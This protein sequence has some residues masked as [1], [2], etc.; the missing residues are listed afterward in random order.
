VHRRN[1]K[2]PFHPRYAEI[3][4]VLGVLRH[5]GKRCRLKPQIDLKRDRTGKGFDHLD[6]P[7]PPRFRR[8]E[9]GTSGHEPECLKVNLKAPLDAAAQH[10]HSHRA[11]PQWRFDF[12]AMDLGTRRSNRPGPGSTAADV[13]P[14]APGFPNF[15]PKAATSLTQPRRIPMAK[16]TGGASPLSLVRANRLTIECDFGLVILSLPDDRAANLIADG[17]SLTV[18]DGRSLPRNSQ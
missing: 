2:V 3:W 7:Q 16:A 10:L 13:D 18:Y 6:D 15:F 14:G 12:G 1:R 17:A 11:S 8:P 4:I 5:L 9:F